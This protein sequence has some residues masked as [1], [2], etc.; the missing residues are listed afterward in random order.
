M[1]STPIVELRAVSKSFLNGIRERV[2]VLRDFSLTVSRGERVAVVGTSGCG[3]TTLLQ[4]C[5]LL[6]SPTA[7]AVIINGVNTVGLSDNEKTLL[8][9]NNIGFVYQMHHLFPEFNVYENVALAKSISGKKNKKEI[10]ELLSE[11]N[12]EDKYYSFPSELSGGERQRVAIARAL[13]TNPSLLLA[14]EPT[15]NLDEVNANNTIR[16]LMEHSKKNKASLVVVTHNLELIRDF[17]RT[18]ILDKL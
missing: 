1:Q 11:L 13:V 7:G 12:L 17:D 16:L 14:D 15:G 8:R 3:K 9:R 5:G 10:R 18:I 4:L 2:N 6:D